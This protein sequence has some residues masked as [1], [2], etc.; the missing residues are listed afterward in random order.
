MQSPYTILPASPKPQQDEAAG[1]S[2]GT[3]L[4]DE[5]AGRNCAAGLRICTE[6]HMMRFSLTRLLIGAAFAALPAL[7]AAEAWPSRPVRLVIAAIA[8]H[9]D[10]HGDS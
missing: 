7:A 3:K 6:R 8:R 5:A 1:R 10:T 9:H 2:S 4:R